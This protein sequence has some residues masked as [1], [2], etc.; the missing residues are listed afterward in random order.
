MADPPAVF[1]QTP[2]VH[3]SE[4]PAGSVVVAPPSAAEERVVARYRRRAR[5]PLP[6]AARADAWQWQL[7]ARCRGMDSA[8][9]FPKI[10]RGPAMLRQA[11]R[12]KAI[13]RQCPVITDCRRHA[14]DVGERHGIWGGLT[15]TERALPEHRH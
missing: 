11:A 9:F 6:P 8:V 1:S 15:T 2:A 3:E 14:L 5:N 7:R 4:P 10:D 12:A 13:C